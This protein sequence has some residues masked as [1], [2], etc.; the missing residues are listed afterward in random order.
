MQYL[1]SKRQTK[2]IKR[3]D[4]PVQVKAGQKEPS[5]VF[6]VLIKKERL[7]YLNQLNLGLSDIF[8]ILASDTTQVNVLICLRSINLLSKQTT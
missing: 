8:I 7:K 5:T 2:W 3:S 4:S 6:A 1:I